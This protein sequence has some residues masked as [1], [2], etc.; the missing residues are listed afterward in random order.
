MN[1]R[2]ISAVLLLIA[3]ALLILG[4][5]FV[6]LRPRVSVGMSQQEVQAR[7]KP[8][9]L[10]FQ[11]STLFINDRLGIYFARRNFLIATQEVM[12]RVGT[13]GTVQTTQSK[14]TWRF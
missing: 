9:A 4:T 1:K 8:S 5:Y 14:W 6:A 2:I 13:D 12:V 10:P 11:R 7:L 3:V